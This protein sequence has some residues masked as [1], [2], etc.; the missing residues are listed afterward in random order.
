M[1][2]AP[3]QTTELDAGKSLT[4]N[5]TVLDPDGDSRDIQYQWYVDSNPIP[6]AD[7]NSFTF[8]SKSDD[9]GTFSILVRA[10]DP[11]GEEVTFGW[12]LTI[13]PKKESGDVSGSAVS[14]TTIILMIIALVLI[15]LL[16]Q[17]VVR[18][19]LRNVS[20]DEEEDEE[21]GEAIVPLRE[22]RPRRGARPVHRKLKGSDEFD[23]DEE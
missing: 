19:K 23:E 15:I 22:A 2:F 18:R 6:G 3:N 12:S 1:G 4:F 10:T 9:S 17:I 7:D 11:G 5:I 20:E 8:K 14:A 21:E 16:M 13:N